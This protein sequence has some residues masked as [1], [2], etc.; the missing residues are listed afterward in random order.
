MGS[1]QSDG[2]EEK[3]VPE[4]RIDFWDVKYIPKDESYDD[5]PHLILRCSKCKGKI[6]FND[7]FFP[8]PSECPFCGVKMDEVEDGGNP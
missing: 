7:Y 5:E 4:T 3:K 2:T 8:L 1:Y 6:D